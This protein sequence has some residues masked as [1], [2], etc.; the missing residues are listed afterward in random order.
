M[1]AADILGRLAAAGLRVRLDPT[2]PERLRLS[3]PDRLNGDL[4]ALARAHKRE[5]LAV[6]RER[7]QEPTY[8]RCLDCTRYAAPPPDSAFWCPLVRAH[9]TVALWVIC[10]GYTAKPGTPLGPTDPSDFGR[11]RT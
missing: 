9:P 6:L 4:L 2:D 7:A 11:E 5:L 8:T 3:P 1:S 10:T